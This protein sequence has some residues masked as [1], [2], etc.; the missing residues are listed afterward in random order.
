MFNVRSGQNVPGLH[1]FKPPEEFVPG[2]RVNADG[3]V[4]QRGST[5]P[6]F[7]SYPRAQYANYVSPS[8][9]ALEPLVPMSPLLKA[10]PAEAPPPPQDWPEKGNRLAPPFEQLERLYWLEKGNRLGISESLMR[11]PDQPYPPEWHSDQ[12]QMDPLAGHC[13][14]RG[15]GRCRGYGPAPSNRST[16]RVRPESSFVSC[17]NTLI[18]SNLPGN[19]Y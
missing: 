6:N 17:S 1:N 8:Q 2:F 14:G 12:I 11:A 10:V 3:N 15:H 7:Q 19:Q 4:R 16:V 5:W 9:E 13:L 18:G